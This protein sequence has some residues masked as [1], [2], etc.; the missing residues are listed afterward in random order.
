MATT[1]DLTAS[2]VWERIFDEDF[3]VVRPSPAT[4]APIPRKEIPILLHE[5]VIAVATSSSTAPSH[6]YYA[7]RLLQRNVIPGLGSNPVDGI[8]LK[9]ALN[10]TKVGIF[11]TLTTDYQLA[12]EFPPWI[13]N[14]SLAIWRYTGPIDD[15]VIELIETLKI[16]VVRV[17]S[18]VK[19]LF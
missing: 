6:W 19:R 8:E 13:T 1:Y 10:R 4:F 16:D 5:P 17:E 7:G 18:I 3:N 15:S 9:C 2:G 14:L 11:P 12:Y